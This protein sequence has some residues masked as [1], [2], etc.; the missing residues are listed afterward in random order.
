MSEQSERLWK[1]PE[2]KRARL[3]DPAEAEFIKHGYG[4][5][6]LNRI[7]NGAKMSKGQAYYYI[8]GK[9][10]LYL[11][12]CKR[13]FSPLLEFAKDQ[14]KSL[15]Y[16]ND[17]WIGVESL[18]GDL[19][20]R[21]AADDKVSKLA[22]TVYGSAS[23]MECLEPLTVQLDTI[24]EDIIQAGQQA[25]EIRTD[26]P[27]GLVRDILKALARG[28]DRWFALNALSLSPQEMANASLGT[29]EM[30]R[31]LVRPMPERDPNA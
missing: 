2:E 1:L 4:G 27:D 17:Y 9:S 3:L 7:L 25:G 15:H 20:Q 29:F 22:L 28:V 21:L 13:D 24:L 16:A 30:I 12:V 26:L 31:N 18:V 11:A 6:S 10:D 8:T 19:V 14:T 5:A 23:A